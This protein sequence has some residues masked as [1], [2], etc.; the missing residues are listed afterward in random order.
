MP[1]F[2]IP[3]QNPTTGVPDFS[4]GITISQIPLRLEHEV[5][6][7]GKVQVSLKIVTDGLERT[8]AL[9]EY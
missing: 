5:L 3:T 8:L 7:T 1:M 9:I 4:Q 2:V 6:D